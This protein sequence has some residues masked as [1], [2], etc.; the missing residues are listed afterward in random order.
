MMS[1]RPSR[2]A[3]TDMT[4]SRGF[5]RLWGELNERVGLSQLCTSSVV[6]W[7]MQLSS[8]PGWLLEEQELLDDQG[9]SIAD[10]PVSGKASPKLP[11]SP[12]GSSS[13]PSH[14]LC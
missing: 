7:E 13:E 9:L 14:T 6:W 4:E 8:A 12:N 1:F 3:F 10:G 5:C 11:L 2:R